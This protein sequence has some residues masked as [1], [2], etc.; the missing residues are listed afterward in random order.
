V[1]TITSYHRLRLPHYESKIYPIFF[2]SLSGLLTVW[3]Y[4]GIASILAYLAA[5]TNLIARWQISTKRMRLFFFLAGIPWIA[6]CLVDQTPVGLL[7]NIIS[8]VMLLIAMWRFDF[9]KQKKQEPVM[10]PAENGL[11]D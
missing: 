8:M 11:D 2:L 9:R 10:I 7:A 3:A 1:V 6:Y 4:T 5:S